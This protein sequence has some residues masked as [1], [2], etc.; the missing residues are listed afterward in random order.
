MLSLLQGRVAID[1]ETVVRI[2]LQA[3]LDLIPLAHAHYDRP[4]QWGR[5]GKRGEFLRQGWWRL[6][7][8]LKDDG[9]SP[10]LGGTWSANQRQFHRRLLW[11]GAREGTD[12][13]LHIVPRTL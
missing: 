8:Q 1:D 7:L 10:H 9:L 13:L 12:G 4:G 2:R 6:A 11:C 3:G 5:L